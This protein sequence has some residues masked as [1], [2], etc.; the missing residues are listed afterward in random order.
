M[1][2]EPKS[3][4]HRKWRLLPMLTES[5]LARFWSKVDKSP[6]HGPEGSCWVWTA[7]AS[8]GY[9]LF[10]M[11]AH[12]SFRASRIMWRIASGD[13]PAPLSVLHRCDNPPCVNPDHLFLGTDKDNCRDAF[14]KG[15]RNLIRCNEVRC[16]KSRYAK[17]YSELD[18]LGLGNWL[19]VLFATQKDANTFRC[20]ALGHR[21]RSLQVKQRR[22]IIFIRS[23]VESKTNGTRR[24][25]VVAV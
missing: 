4:P 13:D 21:T 2:D 3:S 5:D 1:T 6:G 7:G 14:S 10:S 25:E 19:V 20:V 8:K 11:G 17:V 9:G 23:K 12:D 22:Q 15:R 18:R 16:S 24:E